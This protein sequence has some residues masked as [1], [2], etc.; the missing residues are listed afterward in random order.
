MVSSAACLTAAEPAGGAIAGLGGGW[1]SAGGWI[2]LAL[3][4]LPVASK[5]TIAWLALRDTAP[6]DRPPIIH[7]LADLL[8][9]WGNARRDRAR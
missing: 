2:I 8:R 9:P 1:T 3:V 7:A 5:V 4:A 6:G